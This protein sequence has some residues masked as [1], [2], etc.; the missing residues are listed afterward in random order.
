MNKNFNE[1]VEISKER[2]GNDFI[3]NLSSRKIKKLGWQPKVNL[4]EW[5]SKQ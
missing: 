4:M 5:I 3:Y 2:P 1:Y